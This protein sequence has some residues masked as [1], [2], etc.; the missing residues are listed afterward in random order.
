MQTLEVRSRTG[1]VAEGLTSRELVTE[2]SSGKYFQVRG[3]METVRH[4][5]IA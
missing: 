1:H 2:V 4:D 5:I 3:V